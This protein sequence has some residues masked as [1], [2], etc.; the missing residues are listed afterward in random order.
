MLFR[1]YVGQFDARTL[2]WARLVHDRVFASMPLSWARR[3]TWIEAW[4][5][6]RR[7]AFAPHRGGASIYFQG[8]EPVGRYRD[9]GGCCKTGKV[10]IRI[11]VGSDFEGPL[12]A[13]LVAEHLGLPMRLA[14]PGVS[15]DEESSGDG[16]A[17]GSP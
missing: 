15:G 2:A 9:W 16:R 6:T 11:P 7:V 14:R 4:N 10:C 13:H 5:G 12:L 17:T 3:G 8:P 1:S